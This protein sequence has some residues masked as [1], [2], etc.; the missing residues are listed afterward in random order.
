MRV[1][2][3]TNTRIR[4]CGMLPSSDMDKSSAT[5]SQLRKVSTSVPRSIMLSLPLPVLSFRKSA[6]CESG[7]SAVISQ[8]F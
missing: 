4:T 2:D 3:S 6:L 5:W 8:L 1:V 7:E